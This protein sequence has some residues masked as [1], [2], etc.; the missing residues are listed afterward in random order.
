[1]NQAMDYLGT[2]WFAG[3]L[4]GVALALGALLLLRWRRG[5]GWSLPLLLS[6]SALA[7]AGLGGLLP[8]GAWAGWLTGVALAVLFA[9]LVVVVTS[10]HWWGPLGYAGAAL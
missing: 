10:G 6:A 3:A 4:L 2:H 1:M 5:A 8:P 9:M 7:L